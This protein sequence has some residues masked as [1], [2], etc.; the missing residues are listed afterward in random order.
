MELIGLIVMIA[1]VLGFAATW[2]GVLSIAPPMVWGGLAIAGMIITIL[3]RR[4]GN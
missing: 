1:G 2:I 3:T 4:P